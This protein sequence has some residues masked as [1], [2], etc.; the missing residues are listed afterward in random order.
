MLVE[1]CGHE[2]WVG[3]SLT[4][5]ELLVLHYRD[6]SMLE[7]RFRVGGVLLSSVVDFVASVL[8]DLVW[9]EEAAFGCPGDEIREAVVRSG[10]RS[11]PVV[12]EPGPT[13]EELALL[14]T[15]VVPLSEIA[16]DLDDEGSF[17]GGR[18]AGEFDDYRWDSYLR[19]SSIEPPVEFSR[20]QL[21]DLDERMMAVGIYGRLYDESTPLELDGYLDLTSYLRIEPDGDDLNIDIDT[22]GVMT[23]AM[24]D[25]LRSQ[26]A[27]WLHD[28]GVTSAVLAD[29]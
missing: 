8:V 21:L 26:I 17:R 19:V 10:L 16:I 29:R 14:G 2:V 5:A 9:N 23:P 20:E 13:V 7:L 25:A 1:V 15:P 28:A 22:E 12:V 24:A 11:E 27:A 18:A 6:G 3:E 4:A